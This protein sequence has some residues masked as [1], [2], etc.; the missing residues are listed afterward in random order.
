MTLEE[1][2]IYEKSRVTWGKAYCE[3]HQTMFDKPA[4]D[5]FQRD[6]T[7]HRDVLMYLEEYKHYKDL[8]DS[9]KKQAHWTWSE[10]TE[11]WICDC[12]GNAV[13]EPSAFCRM[14]GAEMVKE[15]E[16]DE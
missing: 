8:A 9:L 2:I 6:L 4:G 5:A 11:H 12:C 3:A 15:S 7:Y 14:C 13:N 1:L 10:D 16:F